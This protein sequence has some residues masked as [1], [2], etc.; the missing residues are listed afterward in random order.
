MSEQDYKLCYIDGNKAYFT[1]NF[2][3][4]RGDDWNDAP[5]EHNAEPPYDHYY[6]D[7]QE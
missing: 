2:K 6:E 4:Q 5:Y 7:G 3:R 1:D